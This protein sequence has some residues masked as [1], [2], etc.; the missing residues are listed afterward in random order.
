MLQG[1]LFIHLGTWAQCGDGSQHHSRT[2]HSLADEGQQSVTRRV[3]ELEG[4]LV[5]GATILSA[6]EAVWLVLRPVDEGKR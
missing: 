4:V 5:S 6:V 3:G 2:W 1:R